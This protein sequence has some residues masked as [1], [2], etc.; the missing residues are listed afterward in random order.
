MKQLMASCL[1]IAVGA[2][3]LVAPTVIGQEEE[4]QLDQLPKAV[5]D[6]I[7]AKFP[8]AELQEAA[9]DTDDGKTIYEVELEH[10]DDSY[11]VSVTPEGKITEIEKEIDVEDLPKPVTE[12]LTKKYPKGTPREAAEAVADGK[13]TYEVIVVTVLKVTVDPKG[14][15]LEEEVVPIEDL[16]DDDGD[17]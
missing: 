5:V 3:L 2:L 9:K 11:V 13:T 14:K 10:K 6:A 4:F 15:I 8:G 12:A 1:A 17:E 7:M 16:E